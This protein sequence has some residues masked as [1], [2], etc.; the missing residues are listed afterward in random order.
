ML[1]SI[2]RV[3]EGALVIDDKNHNRSKNTTAIH[4]IHKQRDKMTGGYFM[5]Q[6]FVMLY[7][8]TEYFCLP[9]SFLFY[10]P[11]PAMTEWVREKKTHKKKFGKAP[12]RKPPERSPAHPTKSELALELLKKFSL[13]FPG[14]KV[15]CVLA[16]ALYGNCRFMS[17]VDKIFPNVQLISQIRSNQILFSRGKGVKVSDYFESYRGWQQQ[18]V[19]RGE[20]NKKVIAGGAR[21]YVKS[22]GTKCF[23]IAL[24]YDDEESYRYL[25]A[26]NLSWNMTSVMQSYTLRWLIEVFFEDWSC[27]CG[28]CSLAKQQ[29]YDGSARPLILSLLFDHCFLLHPEQRSFIEKRKP[30]ATLGSLVNYSQAETLCTLI[31]EIINHEDPSFQWAQTE[32]TIRELFC[33]TRTSSKHMI[34]RAITLSPTKFRRAA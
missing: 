25:I 32:S 6:N 4:G 1:L 7:L 29:G 3:S 28:F 15:H 16:D 21:L 11:D 5:G 27:Y 26:S 2:F 10:V 34:G 17:N 20:K 24:K 14:F 23:I 18:I 19:V 13:E 12:F 9:I 8:V 31:S 33:T 22:R 30:M